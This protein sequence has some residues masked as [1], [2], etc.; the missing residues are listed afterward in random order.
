[1]QLM[2]LVSFFP[3]LERD[4]IGVDVYS[5]TDVGPKVFSL[6]PLAHVWRHHQ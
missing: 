3:G 2:F 6:L 4:N 5:D 1:M